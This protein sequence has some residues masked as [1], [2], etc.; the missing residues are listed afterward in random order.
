MADFNNKIKTTVELDAT[1]AAAEIVKLN[2][3]AADTTLD[4]KERLDAKNEAVELQNKLAKQTVKNLEEEVE[5]LKDL[6]GEE[7]KLARAVK[8]LNKARINQ[9]KLASKGV[10]EQN[11]LTK[12]FADSKD[13]VKG[14]DD[15]TGGLLGKMKA[16]LTNP[17]G[18]AIAAIAGAF[19]LFSKAISRSSKASSTFSKIGLKLEG[20]FNGILAVLEP[21]V[22]FIGE[23]LLQALEDPLGAI[24]D[25]GKAI[26]ESVI[27]RFK[28]LLILGDAVAQLLK[29]NFKEAAELATDGILQL[30]TGL[31]DAREKINQF[32]KEAVKNFTKAA[33]ATDNLADK[34][35][36]LLANRIAL[37]KQQLLSLRLAEEQRQIRDDISVDIE[38]R[39]EANKRL[40]EILE[41]Q[42]RLELAL[43]QQ[44]LAI[45]RDEVSATGQ[46]I[47][48]LEAVGDAELKLL[49]IQERIT[50]QRS[51][52]LVN[53]NSLLLERQAIIDEGIVKAEEQSEIEKE[54]QQRDIE[55]Q[56]EIDALDLERRRALGENVLADELAL[57]ERQRVQAISN[58]DLTDKE[59]L[60]LNKEFESE[61]SR[62]REASN[63]AQKKSDDILLK[64]TISNA[65]ESFGIAQEVAIAK[66]IM[67]A[68][69]A[70]SGSFK[71]AAKAYAPP[72]SLFMG[73]LGAAGTVAPIIKGLAD[74]KKA[75][76]SKSKG[77]S[78]TGGTIS[79]P[80]SSGA[81][82]PPTITPEAITDIAANNSAR[83]GIDPSIGGAA[84][85]TAAN[86]IA[87]ATSNNIVFS[88]GQY[89]DFQE[90]VAFKEDK[91]TI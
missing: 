24:K 63:E 58:K 1:Q 29:G 43:A 19:A 53:E 76:F 46:T 42:A 8:N 52:Q 18:L 51:E 34:E 54:R 4:V 74:I 14:L 85:A 25:L 87:G 5:S 91:I 12:S 48:N 20:I 40:G 82:V 64:G 70:I 3:K 77:S 62:V 72:L 78:S 59:W 11:K 2:T 69:E 35:R 49:E 68:P 16:F 26:K 84:S 71:E 60:L 89:S 33:E 28:A 32:A 81:A 15:A 22:E 75:R 23:K 44:S 50:G 47:E 39:I 36:R 79:A 27:N 13:K 61:K 10:K 66:M 65:A 41:E 30:A 31:D 37:E 17:I 86:N 83:L 45:A 55:A 7:K 88:E 90:Q 6:E 57:L 38:K 67:A 73:A 56:F 80:S 21:V 9:T